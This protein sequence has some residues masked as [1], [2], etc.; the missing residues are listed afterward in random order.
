MMN[1]LF[2]GANFGLSI[3]RSFFFLLRSYLQV[4]VRIPDSTMADGIIYTGDLSR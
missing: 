4:L 1:Q 2:N 3:N